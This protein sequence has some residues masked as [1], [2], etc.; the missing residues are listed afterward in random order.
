M[1]SRRR[2]ALA[3][4]T[5]SARLEQGRP[6][7]SES[8]GKEA[9]AWIEFRENG[10]LRGAADA[11]LSGLNG[12]PYLARRLIACAEKQPKA[13]RKRSIGLVFAF[14]A[15]LAAVSVAAAAALN[16]FEQFGQSERRFAEI[17]PQTVI[18]SETA[19]IQTERTGTVTASIANAYYDG[20]SLLI[21]YTIQGNTSFE[22][23]SPTAKELAHMQPTD[24]VPDWLH[25]KTGDSALAKAWENTKQAGMPWGVV[26]YRVSASDHTYTDE[27]LD[28]GPWTETE[29]ASDP[30]VF[31]AIRD[32]DALPEAAQKRDSLPVRID[33]YQSAVWFYFDGHSMY[34]TSERMNLFPMT[35]T[36]E[37]INHDSAQFMG[38]ETINGAK[39]GLRFR[40]PKS[41]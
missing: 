10:R 30:N 4:S 24:D 29:D 33:V 7:P 5:V 3:K 34:T 19:S 2:W 28:L 9:F 12:D 16:L 20:E 40:L 1:K 27:G 35:A 32:F 31:S 37:Q 13:V 6:S 8:A 15:L 26:R 41:A 39:S 21:G 18:D 17:A 25:A 14:V 22:P 11:S 38:F 23:F 36:I